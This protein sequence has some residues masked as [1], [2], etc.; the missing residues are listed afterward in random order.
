MLRN[1]YVASKITTTDQ[2]VHVY[3]LLEFIALHFQS[4]IKLK[5]GTSVCDVTVTLKCQEKFENIF[6]FKQDTFFY[7]NYTAVYTNTLLGIVLLS[8]Y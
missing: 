2:T 8:K 6:L 4:L 1:Q 3:G 7:K 5:I